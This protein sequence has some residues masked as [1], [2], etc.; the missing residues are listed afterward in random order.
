MIIDKKQWRMR[1]IRGYAF[2]NISEDEM[3][4][5][6][7]FIA[8]GNTEHLIGTRFNSRHEMTEQDVRETWF[9]K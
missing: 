1:M 8:D 5:I 9:Y 7:A 4:K 2:L 6:K 3:L